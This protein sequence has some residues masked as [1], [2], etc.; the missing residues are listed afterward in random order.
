M[1]GGGAPPGSRACSA[2]LTRTPP[3]STETES[4]SALTTDTD[5]TLPRRSASSRSRPGCS[6]WGAASSSRSNCTR[7]T[8]E[9]PCAICTRA[10]PWAFRRC[11]S[12]PTNGVS[13]GIS[14]ASTA[15]FSSRK[16][17]VPLRWA[18]N[19]TSAC[20]AERCSG[21]ISRVD[22]IN[23]MRRPSRTTNFSSSRIGCGEARYGVESGR[24]KDRAAKRQGGQQKGR[25]ENRAVRKQGGQKTGRS[26]N[27]AVWPALAAVLPEHLF[28]T[29]LSVHRIVF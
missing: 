21:V 8:G 24:S 2:S 6:P 10:T 4:I 12:D 9:A 22:C 16:R 5:V 3:R 23:S 13:S 25:S 7:S 17:I 14:T 19:S 1:I 26:E 15:S 29:A 27:G 28:L 20:S 18:D 11:R